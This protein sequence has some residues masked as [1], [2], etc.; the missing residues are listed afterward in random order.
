MINHLVAHGGIPIIP[1]TTYDGIGSSQ[2]ENST[3]DRE[4]GE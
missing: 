3:N 1:M 2:D 4:T